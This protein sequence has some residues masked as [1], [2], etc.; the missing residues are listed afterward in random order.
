ML[1]KIF[2]FPFLF[3]FILFIGF[4]ICISYHLQDPFITPR[5]ILISTTVI[6]FSIIFLFSSRKEPFSFPVITVFSFLAFMVLYAI[7]I[8]KSLNPGDAW[9]EWMKT[10]LAFPVML[11]TAVFFRENERRFMLLKF[12]QICVMILSAVYV[13][14]WL[15]FLAHKELEFVF[16]YRL[17]LASTLGN[18]NFYAEVLMLLLPMSVIS[19]FSLKKF[20][21]WLSLFNCFIILVSVLLT[22]SFAA[23]A[24]SVVS[25]LVVFAVYYS[26]R[27]KRKL[28]GLKP[29]AITT[30]VLALA[31]WIAF[32]SG[33]FKTFNQRFE[34][35]Q[36]YI[37]HPELMDST[38]KANSNSAFERMLLWRNS[39]ELIKENPLSG[40]GAGNWK[41]FYPK[42]GIGG[43]RFIEAGY[44]HYEHPHND[45]LLVASEAG[46]PALLTYLLFLFS[47]AWIAIKRIRAGDMEFMLASGILFAVI[48]FM[49]VSIFSFPRMRFYGW[50]IMGVYA[51]LLFALRQK[52]GERRLNV[53]SEKWKLL[54]LVCLGFSAWS[55]YAGIV[56][57]S[58]EVHSLIMQK[59][60]KQ[61]NMARVVR[62]AEKAAS[63]YFPIDETATPFTWYK[64]MAMFYSGNVSGARI[65]FEDALKKNPYHI[66]LLNDLATTYEQTNERE[67]AISFYQ[68]ALS[69]T[70][71]FPQSL[72]NISAC[73]F[74]IGRKD[75]AFFYID[76]LYGIK[77][78]F[79]EKTSYDIY[80]PA[81]LREKI[82]MEANMLPDDIREKV[83]SEAT[84]SALV[85]ATYRM[86]KRKNTQYI[87]ELAEAH[88][89]RQN[90]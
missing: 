18:K 10:F 14:Q 88:R 33:A 44:V 1:K 24:A 60:K 73:Y 86:S 26:R 11:L 7:S 81:I 17:H 15:D 22:Q 53:S 58:G 78:A 69:I 62:E 31:G 56:R 55:F 52:E 47:L 89:L 75:S 90:R 48:G 84:D 28:S 2:S 71:Y 77:L 59:A 63:W 42:F 49:L 4:P 21:K 9:Y 34:T 64:G 3:S 85:N 23:L 50:M 67:K 82:Y 72:L 61:S 32:K 51:G 35:I 29:V 19:F 16:D 76:K 39:I 79:H 30:G 87:S 65:E 27:S 37:Q 38:A 36:Q 66:Q 13:Y 54:L 5:L 41:L 83:V 40:C 46:I 43:T 12:S 80:L 68:R 20:W 6:T 25:A 8:S 74:N 45:Y 70:P 57:Y